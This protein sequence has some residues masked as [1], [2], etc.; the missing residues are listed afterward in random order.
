MPGSWVRVPPLL[1][2]QGHAYSGRRLGVHEAGYTSGVSTRAPTGEGRLSMRLRNAVT[3]HRS[4]SGRIH[5]HAGMP[6][7]RTPCSAIWM[8]A[9]VGMSRRPARTEEP[10]DAA[11]LR[12]CRPV[13]P[14]F[15]ATR[16]DVSHRTR[17]SHQPLRTSRCPMGGFAIARESPGLRTS[18][19]H[20]TGLEIRLD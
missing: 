9:S 15:H 16:N 4:C 2:T 7:R 6:P 3:C 13:H 19:N 14:R 8:F 5:P 17:P 12:E 11:R 18:S 10:V 1:F 20:G